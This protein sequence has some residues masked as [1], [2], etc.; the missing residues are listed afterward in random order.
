[1]RLNPLSP[2]DN[3]MNEVLFCFGSGD[4]ETGGG[5]AADFDDTVST[6]VGGGATKEY[7]SVVEQAAR[8]AGGD[9][10]DYSYF[11]RAQRATGDIPAALSGG[12]N[13]VAQADIDQLFAKTAREDAA[14]DITP[15]FKELALLEEA[16]MDE[17]MRANAKL[18][19]SLNKNKTPTEDVDIFDVEGFDPFSEMQMGPLS[20]QI[21]SARG[22]PMYGQGVPES[23][24]D[25]YNYPGM[26]M[27]GQPDFDGGDVGDFYE[28]VSPEVQKQMDAL[29]KEPARPEGLAALMVP[30]ALAKDMFQNLT[31]RDRAFARQ[32]NMPGNQFQ[33][34]A[35]GQI[36]GIYN[37]REN[38]VYTP[39]S[40]ELFS[41]KAQEAAAGD[42]YGMQRAEDEARR[43]GDGGGQEAA[44]QAPTIVTECPEGYQY[45][46]AT[47]A[48]EYVG[49]G[50]PVSTT[51]T[52]DMGP[53]Q[54][55][56]QYTGV[57]GLQ[58]FV[59]QPSYRAPTSFS[60]L[61]NV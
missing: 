28:F 46:A 12:D 15:S 5:S 57:A 44:V 30:G 17:L 24:V 26:A 8:E 9:L 6:S 49:S 41:L 19:T 52:I 61:Y 36:T 31:N 3:P 22:E 35:Q 50:F 4:N 58:P 34:N 18:Q 51:G 38:A 42:L 47:N 59:L 27:K 21:A 37:P 53:Y 43:G 55:T 16:G 2:S 45:N 23:V 48:C 60:P 40:V 10:S 54:P 20:Q 7:Q 25:D 1:M 29:A 32:V 56:T 13:G 11:E 33:T 39:S 14:P